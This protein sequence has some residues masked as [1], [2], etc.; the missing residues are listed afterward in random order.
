MRIGSLRSA[1][2]LVLMLTILGGS[3]GEMF[4]AGD[5]L[6]PAKSPEEALAS[7]KVPDGLRVELVV[8]EPLVIDPVAIDFG[9][10]GKLWVA[11]MLDYP[12]GIHG[13]YAPGGRIRFV[14]DTNGD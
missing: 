3:G 5:E 4:A 13:D 14:E 7:I 2:N 6:A 9:P 10:D 12:A 8:C 1:R 11:E